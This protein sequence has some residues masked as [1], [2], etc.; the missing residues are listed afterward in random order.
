M[1]DILKSVRSHGLTRNSRAAQ[2]A[3]AALVCGSISSMELGPLE[4]SP[5][6][7][8]TTTTATELRASLTEADVVTPLRV[9][10]GSIKTSAVA[11]ATRPLDLDQ[12]NL[13]DFGDTDAVN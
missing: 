1:A 10:G 12:L 8:S 13:A 2:L 4:L 7:L 9:D 11:I 3:I 6:E 5:L